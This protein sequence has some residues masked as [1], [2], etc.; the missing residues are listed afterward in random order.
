MSPDSP[1]T[2]SV[3]RRALLASASAAGVAALAGCSTVDGLLDDGVEPPE[4]RVPA[5]WRPTPGDWPTEYYGYARTHHNPFASPPR[6]EPTVDWEVDAGGPVASMVVAD[7][8]VFVWNDID[9]VVLALDTETGDE[10]WRASM[11]GDAGRLQYVAGRLYAGSDDRL[12]ALTADGEEQWSTD[13]SD[14]GVWA[15]FLVERE[16]WVFVFPSDG[17]VRLHADTGEIVERSDDALYATTTAGGSLYGGRSTFRACDVDDGGLDERWTADYDGYETYGA[18]AVADGL[19]YRGTN[20]LSPSD[21]EPRGRLSVY[22]ASDGA[23]VAT[24]PFQRTPQTPAV[25]D[26]TVYVATSGVRASNIGREGLL[27]A[28]G[29]DGEVRWRFDPAAGLRTPV[30]ADGTVYTGPFRASGAPLVALDAQSG[31]ELWRRDLGPSDPEIAVADG[32]LYIA[33]GSKVVALRD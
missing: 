28:V 32:T 24:V 2:A 6:S 5:D 18:P 22:G 27:A 20:T 31:D 3:G 9:G 4:R 25:A 26:G 30:V 23:E 14:S 33:A 17:P 19:V 8:L 12:T 10:Q 7:G 21:S 11:P 16:G 13:L 29:H 1:S 15:S